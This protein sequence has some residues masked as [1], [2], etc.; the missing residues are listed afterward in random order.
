MTKKKIAIIV[1]S[2]F[3]ASILAFV[4]LIFLAIFGR[5]IKINVQAM[6]KTPSAK[7]A[8]AGYIEKKYGEKAVF[9]KTE[10]ITRARGYFFHERYFVG[11]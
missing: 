8:A 2:L 7:A 4:L 6:I 11:I 5:S 10:P 1:I 3:G 9:S